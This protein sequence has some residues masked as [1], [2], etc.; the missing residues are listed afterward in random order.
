MIGDYRRDILLDTF[1]LHEISHRP[2]KAIE[3]LE[4]MAEGDG[5]ELEAGDA[6]S[7]AQN[8]V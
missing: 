2:L 1:F 4:E 8:A 3:R 7:S 5:V 6:I